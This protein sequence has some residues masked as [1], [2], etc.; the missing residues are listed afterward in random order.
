MADKGPVTI[1]SR[2]FIRNALLAR[3]QMVSVGLS[4]ALPSSPPPSF[5]AMPLYEE[6]TV[7]HVCLH[8]HSRNTDH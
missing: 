5:H 4:L 6:D 2:K 7:T 8:H 3:R 1:R